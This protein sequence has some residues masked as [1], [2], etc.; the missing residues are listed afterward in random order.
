MGGR[1]WIGII[2]LGTVVALGCDDDVAG[3]P[4]TTAASLEIT[5]A[6]TGSQLDPDDYTFIVDGGAGQSIGINGDATLTGLE[7]GAHEVGL[8]GV[9]P[10]CA[11]T[12]SNPRT[13]TAVA[14]E[15]T[16]VS[17]DVECMF[18][19]GKIAF[20]RVSE[21]GIADIHVIPGSD[22]ASS[23][24]QERGSD[25]AWSPDGTK[26]AF[27]TNRDGIFNAEVYVMEADGSNP[28]N[29]TNNPGFDAEP[30]WSPD[31]TKIAFVTDR[32]GHGDIDAFFEVYVMDADGSNPI[33]L[34]ND[35]ESNDF[36]PAWSPDGT[37]IA[38]TSALGDLGRFEIFVMNADGSSPVN[39][40]NNSAV[41]DFFSAWSPDGTKIAFTTNRD[42]IFNSEVYVMDADG[43]NAVNLTNSPASED[44]PAWS[45]DGTKIAFTTSRDGNFEVYVMDADGSNPSNVTNDPGN[46][47]EP[48][49]SP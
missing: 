40:T 47:L 48:A 42:G 17:F 26:I 8:T 5:T 41:D 9:A 11:V 23:L 37:R 18:V 43:S 19:L 32:D 2:L 22:G 20:A 12:G 36:D 44:N 1:E 3:P 38:F 28:V 39:L 30:T 33:N 45:P 10:N 15:T 24:I 27:T 46:D 25:P 35:P 49:W 29:L 14:D 21:A 16:T 34:T 13:V 4:G 31:G 6:T 7:P